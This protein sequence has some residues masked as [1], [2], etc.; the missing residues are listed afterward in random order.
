MIDVLIRLGIFATFIVFGVCIWLIKRGR[1]GMPDDAEVLKALADQFGFEFS[2]HIDM[3][4]GSEVIALLPR[5]LARRY[6]AIPLTREID[7][8]RIR[9][10]VAISD[11]LDVDAVDAL[12]NI[13]KLDVEPVIVPKKEIRRALTK[14]YP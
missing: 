7:G 6:R 12:R 13:T 2:D 1:Q 11:P 4:I 8:A 14:F 9:V 3:S 5:Q 10:K